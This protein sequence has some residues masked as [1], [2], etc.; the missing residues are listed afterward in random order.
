MKAACERCALPHAPAG[1]K[2]FGEFTL[3]KR[4]GRQ[5]FTARRV[6]PA[7][8]T[9]EWTTAPNLAVT[10]IAAKAPAA[11]RRRTATPEPS[12]ADQIGAYLKDE[13]PTRRRPHKGLPS[14]SEASFP[15]W[16]SQTLW[17]LRA[18]ELHAGRREEL[19]AEA[20]DE[21]YPASAFKELA[22]A[23]RSKHNAPAG[24]CGRKDHVAPY[25]TERNNLSLG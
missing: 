7:W 24:N 6:A 4:V 16:L 3:P 19:S 5:D 23:Q 1:Y 22:D 25:R 20:I 8:R 11:R 14:A 9:S 15:P 13:T 12:V 17:P 10:L 21:S 2:R 18:I